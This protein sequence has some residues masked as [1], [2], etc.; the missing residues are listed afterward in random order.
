M[1]RTVHGLNN[2]YNNNNDGTST[3]YSESINRRSTQK[4]KHN[5]NNGAIA[6]TTKG[7]PPLQFKCNNNVEQLREVRQRGVIVFYN[8]CLN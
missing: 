7:F 8:Y 4:P 1:V 3:R 5:L 6:T 2:N